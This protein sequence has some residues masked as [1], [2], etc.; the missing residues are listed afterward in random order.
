MDEKKLYAS[1]RLFD[2]KAVSGDHE[3]KVISDTPEEL[4]TFYS[5]N[6]A[7]GIIVFDLSKEDAEH[8]KNLAALKKIASASEVPVLGTGN[9]K[10]FEDVKKIIYTGAMGAVLDLDRDENA[11]IMEE[12]SKRFGK[13]K[14]FVSASDPA[15]FK[16]RE[17]VGEYAH[18]AFLI[19]RGDEFD[20][21]ESYKALLDSPV[22]VYV[23]MPDAVPAWIA[24]L[25]KKDNIAGFYGA[26]INAAAERLMGMKSFFAE[27]GIRV[28][29]FDAALSFS[30]LKKDVYGLVPV[31][32]QDYRTKE[33]LMVAYMDE[34][35]FN[36]TIKTGRMTYHS[37]SRNARWVKGETSGHFQYLKSLTADCDKDTLLAKVSQTGVACHTG[38]MSCFFNEIVKKEYIDKDPSRVLSDVY[39]VILDRKENPKEGS[40]TNYLFDKGID[41]ILKKVGEECTE[42]VIAAKNP[43]KE[44]IKYEISDFL[45]HCMVLMV[46][47]GVTWEEIMKDLA[48]R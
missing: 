45:Y 34:E 38:S 24:D 36:A 37:R 9:I 3:G 16:K 44:E 20:E 12:V 35:A 41:K 43:D 21:K 13:D 28:N 48:A 22:P 31:V 10:R 11:G 42:I 18:A 40:Y 15:E 39:D 27:Q 7:D 46:E 14:I 6:N 33:V 5:D 8:E 2:G 25:L 32:V 23:P 26:K 47:K 17:G 29:G 19:S 1:I 4:A 30:D